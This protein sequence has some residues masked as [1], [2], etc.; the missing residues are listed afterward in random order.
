MISKTLQIE[1]IR[2]TVRNI[3]QNR[4]ILKREYS[5]KPERC[6]IHTDHF[7]DRIHACGARDQKRDNG[8][9]PSARTKKAR[10]P[11]SN[12]RAGRK[13]DKIRSA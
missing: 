7:P 1:L 2:I 10:I 11:R 5:R 6:T 3:G 12:G 9:D 13:Q 8:V 4:Q